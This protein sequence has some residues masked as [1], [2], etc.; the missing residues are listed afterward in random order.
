[1]GSQHEPQYH[2]SK[3]IWELY[4]LWYAW[5]RSGTVVIRLLV[6]QDKRQLS[7]GIISSQ[8]YAVYTSNGQKTFDE[9]CWCLYWLFLFVN[10]D[11]VQHSTPTWLSPSFNP[12]LSSFLKEWMCVSAVGSHGSQRPCRGAPARSANTL[13]SSKAWRSCTELLGAPSAQQLNNWAKFG[14]EDTKQTH[15]KWHFYLLAFTS[16]PPTAFIYWLLQGHFQEPHGNLVN[17]RTTFS[18]CHRAMV[19]GC[20]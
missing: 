18:W 5:S 14:Y 17:R 16:P 19:I 2:I 3:R 12:T 4:A 6:D 7:F 9:Q 20:L 15:S 11:L 13:M 10:S 1:M 8:I